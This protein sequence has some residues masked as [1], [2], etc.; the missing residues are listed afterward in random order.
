[1]SINL[2]LSSFIYTTILGSAG[3]VRQYILGSTLAVQMDWIVYVIHIH[4]CYTYPHIRP[5]NT[6]KRV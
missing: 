3:D 2:E 5:N 1:M 4:V 6:R